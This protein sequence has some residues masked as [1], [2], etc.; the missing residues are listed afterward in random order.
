MTTL[1]HG[2]SLTGSAQFADL[3]TI[4][5]AV[6]TLRDGIDGFR[7]AAVEVDN[8]A[9]A[10]LF[11]EMAETRQEAH[12]NVVTV[13]AGTGANIPTESSTI[14]GAMHRGWMQVK[15]AL[16]GDDAIISAALTGENEAASDLAQA[17]ESTSTPEVEEA[18]RRAMLDVERARDRLDSLSS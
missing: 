3:T 2:A 9:L 17:M 10:A 8:P 12:D 7:T 11:N 4:E 13:L 18:L 16:A 15:G 1:S 14:A 6:K 5:R